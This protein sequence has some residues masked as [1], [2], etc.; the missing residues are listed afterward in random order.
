MKNLR[1]SLLGR[2][3]HF[4]R[5]FTNHYYFQRS[6]FHIKRMSQLCWLDKISHVGTL[7]VE[8]P[9]V[10]QALRVQE[11]YVTTLKGY[12]P[13]PYRGPISMIVNEKAY[14]RNPTL[15][16]S[17]FV[18]GKIEVYKAAGDHEAYIR[19]NVEATAKQLR[20]C[21]EKAPGTTS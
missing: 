9:Q 21:L 19:E 2:A 12:R 18:S 3:A 14:R 7:A 10:A 6:A 11:T 16:W 20:A 15:G 1:V 13:K 8:F 4:I 5:N 17:A